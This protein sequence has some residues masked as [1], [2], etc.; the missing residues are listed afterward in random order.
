LPVALNTKSLYADSL[1]VVG[2]TAKISRQTQFLKSIGTDIY[3]NETVKAL[4]Q[5][6]GE[7]QLAQRK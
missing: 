4:Q 3:I 6:I 5:V 1:S 2:D 7:E